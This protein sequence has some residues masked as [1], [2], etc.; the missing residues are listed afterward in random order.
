MTEASASVGL[1]L[2][3]AL[4]VMMGWHQFGRPAAGAKM[5]YFL[6]S[7]SIHVQYISCVILVLFSS[8][9]HCF[10]HFGVFFEL[11]F[12]DCIWQKRECSP[13]AADYSMATSIKQ[14]QVASC[15]PEGDSILFYTLF[16]GQLSCPPEWLLNRGLSVIYRKQ[17]TLSSWYIC[18]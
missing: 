4:L 9:F 11:V 12:T 5:N 3:T 17:W 8:F 14:P 15:R 6:T 7:R 10:W 1:L 18:L 13:K 16:S 2:A